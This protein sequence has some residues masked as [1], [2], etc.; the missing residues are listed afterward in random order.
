MSYDF[1][2]KAFVFVFLLNFYTII[3]TVSYAYRQKY[4][5]FSLL[6]KLKICVGYNKFWN[7]NEDIIIFGKNFKTWNEWKR[8]NLSN[9]KNYHKNTL[10][11]SFNKLFGL[12]M[13]FLVHKFF[14]IGMHFGC[15]CKLTFIKFISMLKDDLGWKNIEKIASKHSNF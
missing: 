13:T 3:F 8:N 6:A 2:N 4:N 14:Y 7:C 11:K 9:K 1:T 12:S 15:M 10:S 5:N